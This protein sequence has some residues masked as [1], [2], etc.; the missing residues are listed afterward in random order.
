MV[1][2]EKNF[3]V[4]TFN[5]LFEKNRVVDRQLDGGHGS[6]FTSSAKPKDDDGGGAI[7]HRDEPQP[8]PSALGGSLYQ[9]GVDD[10]GD[11]SGANASLHDLG[12]M[13]LKTAYTTSRIVDEASVEQR[14]HF[15]DV[16]ELRQS[17]GS[18]S[19]AMSDADRR[20]DRRRTEEARRSE[21]RRLRAVRERD[22]ELES[23]FRNTR[24]EFTDAFGLDGR[25][26]A[27]VL[28]EKKAF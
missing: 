20:S 12:F 7:V 6:W 9:L 27:V 19:F 10:A 16:D 21:H 23:R 8:M 2:V 5:R 28:G 18:Q 17:R 26:A 13:D 15:R 24:S 14:E 3:D 1:D 22:E 11:Y 4:K 25:R